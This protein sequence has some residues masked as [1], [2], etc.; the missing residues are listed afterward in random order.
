[1]AVGVQG[2]RRDA[3]AQSPSASRGTHV[4]RCFHGCSLANRLQGIPRSLL[5]FSHSVGAG[6]KSSKF[7]WPPKRPGPRFLSGARRSTFPSGSPFSRARSWPR[8]GGRRADAVA[9]S[10]F[11]SWPSRSRRRNELGFNCRPS[12]ACVVNNSVRRTF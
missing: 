5:L 4:E 11:P 12:S 2:S 7:T 3:S 8:G 1:M 9:Q 10:H 6:G